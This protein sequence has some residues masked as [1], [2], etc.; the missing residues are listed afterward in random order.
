[1]AQIQIKVYLEKCQLTCQLVRQLIG[2]YICRMFCNWGIF[3]ICYNVN[4][5][6]QKDKENQ[7]RKL[8]PCH[9]GVKIQ[10]TDQKFTDLFRTNYIQYKVPK[11]ILKDDHPLQEI[12]PTRRLL[13][14]TQLKKSKIMDNVYFQI[15]VVLINLVT[16]IIM[17]S[18]DTNLSRMIFPP[19]WNFYKS[20]FKPRF[21]KADYE[22]AVQQYRGHNPL[23]DGYD[24]IDQRAV[25][26]YP[27]V[28]AP[29]DM[30]CSYNQSLDYCQNL[31]IN[32]KKTTK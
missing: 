4:Y 15:I 12:S 22:T 25:P 29:K 32:Q 7:I 28:H 11:A 5:R 30:V 26:E 9:L 18:N 20:H 24:W 27:T 1:M 21:S 17:L 10:S 23:D 19:H 3:C 8:V 16:F 14:N 6:E 2:Y 31:P 13:Q